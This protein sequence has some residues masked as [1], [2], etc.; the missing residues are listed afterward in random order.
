MENNS[1]VD[2]AVQMA[3]NAAD[4]I[5]QKAAPAVLGVLIGAGGAYADTLKVTPVASQVMAVEV[6]VSTLKGLGLS[7][8]KMKQFQALSPENQSA[9]MFFYNG[10]K[11]GN[12]EF[13][14]EGMTKIIRLLAFKE[15]NEKAL[16]SLKKTPNAT[17]GLCV[18]NDTIAELSDPK[19]YGAILTSPQSPYSGRFVAI[20]D[21]ATKVFAEAKPLQEASMKMDSP[22]LVAINKKRDETRAKLEET[23]ARLAESQATLH[24]LRQ[25]N[26]SFA[27]K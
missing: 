4:F 12:A 21:E 14:K 5:T 1:L 18:V 24:T 22:E 7:E 10:L 19:T 2:G 9:A 23:Q 11:T 26:Q 20:R 3:G 27:G 16:I 25:I 15:E 13:Q 8:K 17:V 6:A